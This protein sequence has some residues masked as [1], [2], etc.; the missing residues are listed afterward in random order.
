MPDPDQLTSRL[1]IMRRSI[2]MA[3]PHSTV[4]LQR[5]DVLDLISLTLKLASDGRTRG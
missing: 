1:E 3:P 2:A 4:T 5:E